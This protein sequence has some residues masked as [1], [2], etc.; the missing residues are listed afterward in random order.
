[1]AVP[2]PFTKALFLYGTPIV[3]PR[4]GDIEQWRLTIEQ[5]LNELAAEADRR[6]ATDE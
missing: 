6:V 2:Y 4:D 3:V 1:M 5:S